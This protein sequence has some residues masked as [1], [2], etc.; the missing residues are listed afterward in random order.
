MKPVLISDPLTRSASEQRFID[1]LAVGMR[2][3]AADGGHSLHDNLS[4]NKLL[5]SALG[6]LR[7]IRK[8]NSRT[9]VTSRPS[10]GA[11]AKQVS[12]SVHGTIAPVISPAL[13]N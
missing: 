8:P 4:V 2:T 13:P 6:H 5:P 12:G 7:Q 10:P 11:G 3:D 9:I 1:G